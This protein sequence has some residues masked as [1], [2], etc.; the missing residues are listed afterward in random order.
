MRFSWSCALTA[1]QPAAELSLLCLRL[2]LLF[3][4]LRLALLFFCR[5]HCS[6]FAC[7][8]HCSSLFSLSLCFH[9]LRADCWCSSAALTPS[10]RCAWRSFGGFNSRA[11]F[12]RSSSHKTTSCKIVAKNC[13]LSV[14]SAEPVSFFF[15]ALTPPLCGSLQ[16]RTR[17]LHVWHLRHHCVIVGSR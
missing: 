14:W 11:R 7:G 9:V 6:S 13:F 17:G 4:C 1:H 12:L 15:P 8:W 16:R 5:W 10:A 2:A 3:F